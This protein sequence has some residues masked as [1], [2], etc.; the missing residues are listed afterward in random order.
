[1]P[2]LPARRSRHRAAAL[3]LALLATGCRAQRPPLPAADMPQ[4]APHIELLGRDGCGNSATMAARLRAVLT[5]ADGSFAV[6]D[7]DALAP[8]DPRRGHGA[9]TVLVDGA[10][11]FGAPPPAAAPEGRA[12]S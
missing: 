7:L 1:M 8:E 5:P 2:A 12:P 9:P 10:D 6:V 3:A 11:L 4:D